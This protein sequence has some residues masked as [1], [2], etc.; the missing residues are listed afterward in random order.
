MTLSFFFFSLSPAFC[1]CLCSYIYRYAALGF[2]V[3]VIYP[4]LG[5]CV[6]KRDKKAGEEKAQDKPETIPFNLV[7]CLTRGYVARQTIPS[8][9]SS[10]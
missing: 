8:T 1:A 6:M 7:A 9:R 2:L 5:F 4:R 3:C 10:N